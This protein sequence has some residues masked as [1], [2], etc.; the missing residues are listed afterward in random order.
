MFPK[1]SSDSLAVNFEVQRLLAIYRSSMLDFRR[2]H[3]APLA[4]LA[5]CRLKSVSIR[6]H[7]WLKKKLRGFLPPRLLCVER[8]LVS[9]AFP[10]QAFPLL[11]PVE[12]YRFFS[13]SI[14]TVT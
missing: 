4:S 7:P 8:V 5:S 3:F 12:S 1:E 13:I 2:F 9:G 10:A 6:A 14:L 11:P